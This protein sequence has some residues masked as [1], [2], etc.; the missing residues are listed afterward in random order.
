VLVA[1]DVTHVASGNQYT[2]PYEGHL[3]VFN[4]TGKVVKYQ[5][6]TDT[7]LHERAA[8]GK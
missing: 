4:D 1:F 7:A 6:V 5:H 8:K 3:W 2:F